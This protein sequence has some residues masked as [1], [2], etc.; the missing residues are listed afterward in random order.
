LDAAADRNLMLLGSTRQLGDEVAT[1]E[2][3]EVE[4]RRPRIDPG[5][6]GSVMCSSNT[7]ESTPSGAQGLSNVVQDLGTST[8]MPF[9]PTHW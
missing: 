3:L 8:A 2:R 5:G 1:V 6:Q 4:R 7:T 9:I